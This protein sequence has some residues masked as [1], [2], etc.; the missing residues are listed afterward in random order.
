MENLLK[1]DEALI[2]KLRKIYKHYGYSPFIMSKFEPYDL[3][4]DKKDFLVSDSIITFTDTDGTLL[5]LKPD[6]TLSIVKNY[7][8]DAAASQKT[9]YS[10]TVYRAAGSGQGYREIM[11][12]G[13]EC[14]GQIDEVSVSEVL[15]LAI[16]SLESISDQYVLDISHMGVPEQL[17]S[18]LEL[19]AEQKSEVL[20]C[21]AEKNA[22]ALRALPFYIPEKTLDRLISL[23]GVYGPVQEVLRTVDWL[24]ETE[25]YSEL[26][27]LADTLSSLQMD[28]HV[29][30]DFSITGSRNYYNGLV[31]RG[32]IAAVPAVVLSG[33][34][35]DNLVKKM[36]KNAGGIGFAVYLNE[37]DRLFAPNDSYDYDAVLLY[38]GI[39]TPE[40]MI[41]ADH[42]RTLSDQV[43]V[44]KY[45]PE[46]CTCRKVYRLQNG[47]LCE[48]E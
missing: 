10:E 3:Y 6:V 20:S 17:L 5:A 27:Q 35:Y 16:K 33:G 48:I 28:G 40:V 7:R 41:A 42:L 26:S 22:D 1:Y 2:L 25:A 18:T 39:S 23:I 4:A 32:Y 37:L 14:I 46:G 21:L 34:Q 9:Y 44:S 13:V 47:R 24:R 30:L 38:D 19:S 31:F 11:Q 15:S 36:H 12:T 29:N 45:M 8:N 43:L